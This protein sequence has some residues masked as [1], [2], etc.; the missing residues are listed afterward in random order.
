[1]VV[2]QAQQPAVIG[3]VGSLITLG[4]RGLSDVHL[5]L[6]RSK[7]LL[8]GIGDIIGLDNQRFHRHHGLAPDHLYGVVQPFPDNRRAQN[9]VAL[10]DGLQG[11]EEFGQSVFIAETQ[12]QR[13]NIGIADRG[14]QMVKQNTGLQGGQRVDIL[15]ITGTARHG[16]HY[17]IDLRLR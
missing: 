7:A 10:N 9:V 16:G 6:R 11:V 14:Q 3:R 17:G 1:M 13:R 12:H 5:Q 2:Q 4:H 8:Q 15:H